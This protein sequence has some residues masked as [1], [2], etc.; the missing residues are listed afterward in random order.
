M[1]LDIHTDFLP[2]NFA[3]QLLYPAT[4]PEEYSAN[5]EKISET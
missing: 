1:C 2:Q 5:T 3:N 4:I